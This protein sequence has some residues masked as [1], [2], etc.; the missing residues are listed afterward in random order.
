MTSYEFQVTEP[1]SKFHL[2]LSLVNGEQKVSCFA[3]FSEPTAVLAV[4]YVNYQNNEL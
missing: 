4:Y 2:N 1:N 3:N